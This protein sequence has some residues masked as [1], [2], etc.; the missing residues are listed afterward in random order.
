MSFQL[1]CLASALFHVLKRCRSPPSPL[2]KNVAIRYDGLWLTVPL[3]RFLQKNKG[4]IAIPALRNIAFQHLSFVVH[5]ALQVVLLAI[6]LHESLIQMPL[7]SQLGTTLLD[8][9]PAEFFGEHRAIPVPPEPDSF[10]ADV[11]AALM[12]KIFHVWKRGR[13][14]NIQHHL[15]GG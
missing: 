13:K 10:M 7:P 8:P 14:P 11:D 3:H 1:G 9:I 4:R 15:P 6:D 2:R 12:K 5:G